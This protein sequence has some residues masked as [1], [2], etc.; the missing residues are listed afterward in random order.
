M[1]LDGKA[2]LTFA[3]RIHH[4]QR[5]SPVVNELRKRG[6]VAQYVI[7]DN[8]T[9]NDPSEEFLV[10]AGEDFIHVLDFLDVS[11]TQRTTEM[12]HDILGKIA[13]HNE[14]ESDIRTFVSP[15][16]L[17]YSVREA[18]EFI[19]ATEKALDSIKPDMIMVL[20]T[21]NFWGRMLAHLGY[22]R[23]ISVVAYQEGKLRARDQKTLNKQA[24]AADDCTRI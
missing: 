13:K 1:P 9:Q 5:L 17:A 24:T 12:T 7:S 3:G 10:P 8:A 21:N 22:C 14:M 4:W 20:H 16:W 23:N 18:C 11:A 15:F 6:C 19:C 2:I